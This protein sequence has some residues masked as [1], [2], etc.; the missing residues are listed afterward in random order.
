V[1]VYVH[2]GVEGYLGGVGP[3]FVDL[4]SGATIVLVGFLTFLLS[5]AWRRF[6]AKR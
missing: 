3:F 6:G 5:F 2:G 1:T 4:P